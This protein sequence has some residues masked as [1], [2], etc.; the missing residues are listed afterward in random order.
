[1]NPRLV[2]HV[3]YCAEFVQFANLH[4]GFG[5]APARHCSALT[6]TQTH[7]DQCPDTGLWEVPSLSR[8]PLAIR[9][10]LGPML[11]VKEDHKTYRLVI[12]FEQ[13]SRSRCWD[14]PCAWYMLVSGQWCETFFLR[15]RVS[16]WRYGEACVMALSCD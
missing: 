15:V 12:P 10:S 9:K 11:A 5:N 2:H 6:G 14:R 7:S 3:F 13:S 16:R 1:M 8:P 4:S